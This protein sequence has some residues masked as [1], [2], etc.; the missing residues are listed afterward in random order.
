MSHN[1]P[2]SRQLFV[3]SRSALILL[4]CSLAMAHA[5][6]Q[7]PGEII[8]ETVDSVLATLQNTTLNEDTK[9]RQVKGII[10]QHFDYR[11]MSSRVLATNWKQIAT[12]PQVMPNRAKAG[13]SQ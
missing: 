12:T 9:R 6:A 5:V 2:G 1:F 10:S 8:R 11:A 13:N 7:T 4:C 3:T